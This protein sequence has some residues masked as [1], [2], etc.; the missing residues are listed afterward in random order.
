MTSVCS[1]GPSVF[2]PARFDLEPSDFVDAAFLRLDV[3][4]SVSS[5]S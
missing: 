2:T 1:E 5:E 3:A 4:M